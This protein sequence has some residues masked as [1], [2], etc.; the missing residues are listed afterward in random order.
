M[1]LEYFLFVIL[2][3]AMAF[4]NMNFLHFDK[5]FIIDLPCGGYLISIAYC[6]FFSFFLSSH[7]ITWE[8]YLCPITSTVSYILLLSK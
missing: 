7:S 1:L 5:S 3:N 4:V 8:L 2:K 6:L